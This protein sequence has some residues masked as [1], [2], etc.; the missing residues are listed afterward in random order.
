M[1]RD[2]RDL[3]IVPPN[4]TLQE[5]LSYRGRQLA[6]KLKPIGL[7]QLLEPGKKGSALTLPEKFMG[8]GAAG[9]YIQNPESTKKFE[10]EKEQRLWEQKEKADN[11]IR[12]N[13]GLPP[14][15]KRRMPKGYARGG[16]VIT[17]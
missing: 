13:Q 16:P 14:L 11:A 4:A 5:Q 8:F 6:S 3:P 15:P 2:W 12:R 1:N 9:A 17:G 7:Q 10:T